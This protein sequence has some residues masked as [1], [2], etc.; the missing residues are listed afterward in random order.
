MV[1]HADNDTAVTRL[2]ELIQGVRVAM[3]TSIDANG[4]LH[5]R[6]MA[7]QDSL[8]DGELWFFTA[9]ST[10]KVEEV[11]ARPQVN[12][13]YVSDH[14]WVSVSGIAEVLV[15][16]VR[17]RELWRPAYKA[18]FPQ[19][20]EDAD[21]ALLRVHPTEAEYWRSGSSVERIAGFLKAITTGEKPE[22]GEHRWVR[23]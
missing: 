7:A 14:A 1:K 19:G 9:Q 17:M 6:P 10:H 21:L 4:G 3:L 22:G 18:W 5:S 13:C 23:L 2:A 8:F 16:G 15:D 12:L 11:R 20:L